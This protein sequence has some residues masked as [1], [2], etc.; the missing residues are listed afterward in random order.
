MVT[1]YTHLQHLVPT[2]NSPW[3]TGVLR[4]G[5][6]GGSLSMCFDLAVLGLDYVYSFSTKFCGP[7]IYF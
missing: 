7:Q 1:A 2:I 3:E 5:P 4:E 6:R